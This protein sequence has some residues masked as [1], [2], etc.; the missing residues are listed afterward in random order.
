MQ[1]DLENVFVKGV[2]FDFIV[3]LLLQHYLESFEVQYNT[4]SQQCK[5]KVQLILDT[6][7]FFL[8]VSKSA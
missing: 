7:S 8:L 5:A 1:I 6:M 4:P 3:F 2:F